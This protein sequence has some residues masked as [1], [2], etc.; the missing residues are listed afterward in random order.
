MC[1][2]GNRVISAS[3]HPAGKTS[4]PWICVHGNKVKMNKKMIFL[5]Y[6]FD[7]GTLVPGFMGMGSHENVYRDLNR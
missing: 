1:A 2:V 5:D 6:S 4:T 7:D 3:K